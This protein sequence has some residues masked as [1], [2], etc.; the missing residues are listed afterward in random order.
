MKQIKLAASLLLV[1]IL[2]AG[3]STAE[4]DLMDLLED[5]TEVAEAKAGDCAAQ[6][7][8]VAIFL[9]DHRDAIVKA[10]TARE[11]KSDAERKILESK[12][13]PLRE[14]FVQRTIKAMRPCAQDPQLADALRRL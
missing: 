12:F 9:D 10:Q 11:G 1:A 5:I 7:S 13:G 8:A 14:E 4:E 2:S 6:A 3:C